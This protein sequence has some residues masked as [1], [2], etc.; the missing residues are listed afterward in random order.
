MKYI[1]R[2]LQVGPLAA[3][4][5][6]FGCARTKAAV[7]IDPG[8]DAARINGQLSADGLKAECVINTHGHFDHTGANREFKL[9]VFIHEADAGA[10]TAAYLRFIKDGDV[11]KAGDLDIQVIHTPGHSP[12]SV[13]LKCGDIL[14]SG[15]TL[16]A[17]SIGRTD[18]NGGSEQQM[19]E[20]LAKLVAT[21]DDRTRIYPGHGPST[22]MGQE[23][24]ENPFL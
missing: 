4:C 13:C 19:A 9:P 14:F 7:I 3:N 10:K 16:F 11:I 15:D 20:S 5:Y 6:I 2:A 18:L 17:G 23:R 22:T 12:G 8:G 1:L 21:I 24:E